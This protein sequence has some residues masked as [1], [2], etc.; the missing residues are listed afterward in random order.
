MIDVEQSETAEL[1]MDIEP[2]RNDET[3]QHDAA[4]LDV[5]AAK[6]QIALLDAPPHLD[7][8]A[9]ARVAKA[10]GQRT[11]PLMRELGQVMFGPGRLT[12]HEYFYYRL[13]DPNLP[14]DEIRRFVGKARQRRFHTRCNDASW[15]AAA[16]DKALFYA[17]VRGAGLP[18][19][20]TLAV[21]APGGR[22]FAA[23]TLRTSQQLAAFLQRDEHYPL[24]VKPIDG[25]Y[26]VGA[27][28]LAAQDGRWVQFSTGEVANLD[29]VVRFIT[30][31]G[32]DGFLLQ[33]RLD[34]HPVFREAFGGTLSTIRFLVLL[35]PQ[36]AAIESAVLK[37]PL[38]CNSADNYWRYGNMIGALD[39]TGTVR[40]AITGV[41]L[42]MREVADHPDTG[43]TLVGLRVPDWQK[44]SDLCRF[45]AAM[46]PGIRTQSWDIALTGGGPVVMELN[47]GGD[48]NCISL[49]TGAARS[50]QAISNTCDGAGIGG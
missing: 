6:S 43:A 12:V 34:P 47:F 1:C 37:I 36:G 23:E 3:V 29:D 32:G 39:G 40:R 20:E 44:A 2:A 8:R 28:S 27:L 31:F 13:D 50:P 10:A 4:V 25:I 35:S 41:G 7:I 17:A 48:L 16:H 49:H 30:E 14:R 18:T 24:F 15:H 21:Y 46:F 38:G 42:A 45:A 33:R 11:R 19:P 22:A 26:S 5:A 9:H